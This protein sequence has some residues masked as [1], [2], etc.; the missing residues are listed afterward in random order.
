MG[1]Y[2]GSSSSLYFVTD[3]VVIVWD[4]KE[5]KEWLREQ[6]KILSHGYLQD[7]AFQ[8]FEP[9]VYGQI[10]RSPF[11]SL[12]DGIPANSNT[13]NT[14]RHNY[15]IE[16]HERLGMVSIRTP[17]NPLNNLILEDAQIR[18]L[19]PHGFWWLWRI[20]FLRPPQIGNFC[21]DQSLRDQAFLII[22]SASAADFIV[23][24]LGA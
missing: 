8:P 3:D 21:P 19:C 5:N 2:A 7:S 22:G 10:N 14:A 17:D 4:A 1:I 13:V 18:N 12:S 20:I 15:H 24:D 16:A 9:D 6:W 11:N 23:I